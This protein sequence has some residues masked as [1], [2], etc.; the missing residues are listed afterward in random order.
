MTFDEAIICGPILSILAS[1]RVRSPVSVQIDHRWKGG[2]YDGVSEYANTSRAGSPRYPYE[3]MV[4]AKLVRRGEKR[5][6]GKVIV[7]MIDISKSLP[8]N[9]DHETSS[10]Q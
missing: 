1:Q 10:N 8:I 3:R 2:S 5:S 6:R 7:E 4:I 9:A